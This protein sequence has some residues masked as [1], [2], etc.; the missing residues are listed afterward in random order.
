MIDISTTQARDFAYTIANDIHEYIQTHKDE[1]EEFLKEE[2][3]YKEVEYVGK[4]R[5]YSSKTVA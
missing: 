3:K 1:Y 2:K 5:K 4:N